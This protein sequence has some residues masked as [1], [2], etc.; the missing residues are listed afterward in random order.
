MNLKELSRSLGLSQ[1]TVSRALNGYPEVSEA[2]R[3]RVQQAAERFN[4]A[5]STR[6]KG[7]AT[8]RSLAIGH[9]IPLSFKHEMLNPIFA[10][11]IAG[12]GETYA[13]HGYE[14]VI[15][16]LSE[17]GSENDVY[18]SLKRRKAVD[19]V[20]IQAPHINDTRIP[21]LTD[22]GLPFVVHG[23][24]SGVAAPYS[25]VDVN[26]KRAF[27]TATGF[28]HDLGHRRIGLI[29]GLE[30][31]DFAHRR[32]AGFVEALAARGLSADPALMYSSEM[33][34]QAGF[35][36]ATRMLDL[37]APPTALL[38]ASLITAMGARRAIEARGMRLARD[39]SIVT[40]D[41]N[42]SYLQNGGPTPVFT[43]TR[44]SVREAGRRVA[45]MLI[46]RIANPDQPPTHDL[47]EAELIV[48]QSTGPA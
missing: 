24:A 16:V 11:F 27:Q 35:D 44:S 12:A 1:T 39:V 33:T 18:R 47:L 4:Y 37:A 32:R 25:W 3:V 38:T 26:N 7:L 6:A 40:F 22:L 5:P 17:T 20:V 9:V 19:G 42:L 2:T 21:F 14:M 10:D 30:E 8:G 45:A 41:D 46:D 13:R 43:A 23:R 31:M 15:S 48:G 36:A 28:L 29:N 34:E